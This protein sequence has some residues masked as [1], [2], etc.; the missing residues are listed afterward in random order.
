MELLVKQCFL[1]ALLYLS[2]GVASASNTTDSTND[3]GEI[4]PPSEEDSLELD[5][6]E[7]MKI[8]VYTTLQ[9]K[10]FSLYSSVHG[11]SNC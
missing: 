8:H 9:S 10:Y 6:E 3:S 1:L 4:S 5:L 11:S 2:L 7:E